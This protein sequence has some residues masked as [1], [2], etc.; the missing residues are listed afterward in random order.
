MLKKLGPSVEAHGMYLPSPQ[1]VLIT[2]STQH[3]R[4]SNPNQ[5]KCE[6]CCAYGVGYVVYAY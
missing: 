4:N 5:G 1:G 3:T 6:R 2:S